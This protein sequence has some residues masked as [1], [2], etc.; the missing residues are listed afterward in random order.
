MAAR[1]LSF[2]T[3]RVFILFTATETH[4][5][6]DVVCD[7]HSV[8][9]LVRMSQIQVPP[10]NRIRNVCISIWLGSLNSMALLALPAAVPSTAFC[11]LHTQGC[12]SFPSFSPRNRQGGEEKIIGMWPRQWCHCHVNSARSS[13]ARLPHRNTGKVLLYTD[14]WMC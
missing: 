11:F 6:Q 9:H 12:C 1:F 4:L 2:I 7:Y 10:A 8:P 13:V 14:V 5:Q 3:L